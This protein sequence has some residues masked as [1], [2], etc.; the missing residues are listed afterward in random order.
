MNDE[1]ALAPLQ[2]AD[3]DLDT[4]NQ[5]FFDIGE[6]GEILEVVFKHGSEAYAESSARPSLEEA[7]QRLVAGT[8]SGVQ[9]RYRFREKEWW[10]TLL[11]GENGVRLVR[12]EYQAPSG[13]LPLAKE[14]TP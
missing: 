8:V 6:L 13:E 14:Q 10:D 12:L 3:L 2:Q 11:R 4:V 5:L 1:L 9:L 7:R